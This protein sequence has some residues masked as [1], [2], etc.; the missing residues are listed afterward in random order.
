V[1]Q[2]HIPYSD[3]E[4]AGRVLADRL[5][6]VIAPPCVVG[7]IPRGG[8][9]VALPLAERLRAPLGIVFVRKLVVPVAPE[10]AVGAI[11]EDGETLLDP[12]TA[13]SVEA[14]PEELAAARR[15]ARHEIERQRA[16]YPSPPLATLLPGATA[17]LVDDGLATGLTM[18]AAVA[19]VRRHGVREVVV[20]VPCAAASAARRFE[21]EADRFVSPVV[22]GGSFAVG[23]FYRDFHA[24]SDREVLG[25]L[26]RARAVGSPKG[27]ETAP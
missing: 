1:D 24:V 21:R 22:A 12:S 10:V 7:A 19:W 4:H 2:I 5:A 11:D 8:L 13:E 16:A 3:R 17:V 18:R 15:R 20:A 23:S 14:T 25:V 9:I 6:G 26:E 27:G